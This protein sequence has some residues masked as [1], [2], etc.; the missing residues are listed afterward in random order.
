VT[1]PRR[2][3]FVE[4]VTNGDREL[5]NIADIDRVI[6][7][8]SGLH[9]RLEVTTSHGTRTLT[10]SEPYRK[11]IEILGVRG[12]LHAEPTTTTEMVS[13]D[14]ADF[15]E[16]PLPVSPAQITEGLAAEIF[17][18]EAQPAS[19]PTRVIERLS[20]MGILV[21]DGRDIPRPEPE[22]YLPGERVT[23]TNPHD[24]STWSGEVVEPSSPVPEEGTWVFVRG[25]GGNRPLP[26]W[27]RTSRVTQENGG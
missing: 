17:S 27:V 21:V 26:R 25:V 3:Q 12:E 1:K 18:P 24:G 7:L 20:L 9:T 16:E 15:E 13:Y 22:R 11:V 6:R 19:W 10:V 23:V 5:V 2:A 14:D 8:E 4:L